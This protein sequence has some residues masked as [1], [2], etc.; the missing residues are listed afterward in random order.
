MPRSP[1]DDDE[2]Q[3]GVRRSNDTVHPDC[4]F[5]HNC[6]SHSAIVPKRRGCHLQC[7]GWQPNTW[8]YCVQVSQGGKNIGHESFTGDAQTLVEPNPLNPGYLPPI[9]FTRVN[10][11]KSQHARDVFLRRTPA[12][13][14]SIMI[15]DGLTPP[16]PVWYWVPRHFVARSL[17]EVSDHRISSRSMSRR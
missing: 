11:K 1:R 2:A 17:Q 10:K 3:E 12:A 6:S 14:G 9:Q 15:Y 16:P 13:H 5:A 7:W 4:R 8:Y